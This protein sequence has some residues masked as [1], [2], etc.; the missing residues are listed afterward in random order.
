MESNVNL[1]MVDI[2]NEELRE[3]VLSTHSR[4]T[5]KAAERKR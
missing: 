1:Q 2:L 5:V 3:M 4:A